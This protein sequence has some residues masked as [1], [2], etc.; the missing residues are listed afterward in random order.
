ME[1]ML[2]A[3]KNRENEMTERMTQIQEKRKSVSF[4]N[5]LEE[6]HSNRIIQYD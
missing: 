2:A 4:H 6:I 5:V 3:I 1:D